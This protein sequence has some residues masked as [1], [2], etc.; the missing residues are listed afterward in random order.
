MLKGFLALAT[1][2][3]TSVAMAGRYWT[4]EAD[5]NWAN[6]NNWSS[7]DVGV[8]GAGAPDTSTGTIY[9]YKADAANA[10]RMEE[11]IAELR[12]QDLIVGV[13][14]SAQPLVLSMDDSSSLTVNHIYVSKKDS[15]STAALTLDSGSATLKGSLYLGSQDGSDATFTLAGGTLA[16]KFNVNIGNV[17]GAKGHLEI[18]GGELKTTDP[19]AEFKVGKATG[20]TGTAKLSGGNVIVRKVSGYGTLTFDG[21]LL[22]SA[23][24]KGRLDAQDSNL[25]LAATA[26]GGFIN[27]SPDSSARDFGMAPAN[28]IVK[29]GSSDLLLASAVTSDFLVQE[30]A[31][32]IAQGYRFGG[33][34]TI[35]RQGAVVVD[36]TGQTLTVGERV[37]LFGAESLSKPEGERYEDSIFLVGPVCTYSDF[38]WDDVAKTLSVKIDTVSEG[39]RKATTWIKN[40]AWIDHDEQWSNDRP[41]PND[42]MIFTHA[43]VVLCYDTSVP[44]P[45]DNGMIDTIAI[46]GARVVFKSGN[47][48]PNLRPYRIVG[49]GTLACA[50]CGIKVQDGETLTVPETITLEPTYYDNTADSWFDGG[51]GGSLVVNG[52]FVCTNGVP[53]IAKNV[54]LN[55]NVTIG[56]PYKNDTFGGFDENGNNTVNSALILEEGEILNFRNNNFGEG[57]KVVLAGGN[58][59]LADGVT[60][61]RLE[62]TD[63]VYSTDDLPAHTGTATVFGGVIELSVASVSVGVPVDVADQLAELTFA[64]GV[65]PQ[66]VL[67]VVD[68][69]G[70]VYYVSVEATQDGYIVTPTEVVNIN[71]WI[72]GES[73]N[74][75]T[76]SCWSLG[77]PTEAQTL[78]FTNDCRVTANAKTIS[79]IVVD[80]G[81]TATIR[82]AEWWDKP[83]FKIGAFEVAGE[84]EAVF[85]GEHI[86][87][88]SLD[89]ARTE[90]PTNLVL[91]TSAD[92]TDFRYEMDMER[93][94]I[95]GRM[96][97]ASSQGWV[98]MSNCKLYGD[99]SAFY[100]KLTFSDNNN[101]ICAASAGTPNGIWDVAG[102]IWFEVTEGT[103]KIGSMSTRAYA[104]W[105][106]VDGAVNAVVEFGGLNGTCEFGIFY[107]AEKGIQD[108]VWTFWDTD[109]WE[110]T[111]PSTD[112][113]SV[114]FRKVGTGKWIYGGHGIRDIEVA[115]GELELRQ[116]TNTYTR[117]AQSVGNY[118]IDQLV[119]KAGATLSGTAG[120][121]PIYSLT[122]E[123]NSILKAEFASVTNIVDEAEVVSYTNVFPVV[124]GTAT[125]DGVKVLVNAGEATASDIQSAHLLDATTVTG[126]VTLDEGS[127][128]P[129]PVNTGHRWRVMNRSTYLCLEERPKGMMVI[130][131]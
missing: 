66:D 40:E 47:A 99:N 67:R 100:G 101:H 49:S 80:A 29:T 125:V 117:Y 6:S 90:I 86:R 122:M 119:V 64:A 73:G 115:G 5:G 23:H 44:R 108:F 18:T 103:V 114:K 60:I 21:G 128:L 39:T 63:G 124:T 107:D 83:T 75:T 94:D 9:F 130:V 41:T 32:H 56:T 126:L 78:C 85:C 22:S 76:A 42:V 59:R 3:L 54:T 110:V 96:V 87:L 88:Q 131:R 129:A 8:S 105:K 116:S 38:Q 95:K 31:V 79:K 93:L 45:G 4:G 120:D 30:G 17:S 112:V 16:V 27:A 123:E 113:P 25:T 15:A 92:G 118:Q 52:P 53:R 20:S 7:S 91:Q 65:N 109:A 55:G 35:G 36:M 77:V 11:T 28:T 84:G 127:T 97:T 82:T 33:A 24:D 10:P 70:T 37:T 12:E 61:P 81:V 104:A 13:G 26:N 102:D 68:G 89:N 34:L 111:P 14:T 19:S 121:Q 58:M 50:H 1:G 46:R 72:G 69:E 48:H 43:A 2:A 51:D 62:I 106:S 98:Q 57:A 74:W 71:Y